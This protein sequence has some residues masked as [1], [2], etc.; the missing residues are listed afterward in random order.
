MTNTSRS[1]SNDFTRLN[2]F[3]CSLGKCIE[4]TIQSNYWR[5]FARALLLLRLLE[6]DNHSIIF[7]AQTNTMLR[8]IYTGKSSG[9]NLIETYSHGKY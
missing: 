2:L 7:S 1:Q 4:I 5:E 6:D 8:I 3:E 9:L